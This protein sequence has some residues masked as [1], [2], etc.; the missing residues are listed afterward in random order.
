MKDKLIKNKT[1]AKDLGVIVDNKLNW[2]E[3]VKTTVAKARR[4]A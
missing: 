2:S 3:H 1:S 4:R